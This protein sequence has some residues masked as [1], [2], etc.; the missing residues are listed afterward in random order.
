VQHPRVPFGTSAQCGALA[1][2]GPRGQADLW[3]GSQ[4]FRFMSLPSFRWTSIVFVELGRTLS[5][6]LRF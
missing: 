3:G 6:Y 1:Q 5:A 4:A 2:E